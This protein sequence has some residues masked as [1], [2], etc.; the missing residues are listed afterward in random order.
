MRRFALIT[1]IAALLGGCTADTTTEGVDGLPQGLTVLNAE[2]GS[3]SMAY[4]SADVVIYM[5]SLRGRPTAEPYQN[6]PESPDF[7]VDARFTDDQ[8][9]VFYSQ[10]GGDG[11]VDAAWPEALERQIY[12]QPEADSNEILFRIAEDSA[13]T[14]YADIEEQLGPD[15]AAQLA[16]EI[17]ALHEFAVHAVEVYEDTFDT[18]NEI[19]ADEGMPQVELA[20]PEA[21]VAYGSSDG[22]PDDSPWRARSGRYYIAIHDKSIYEF[23]RHSSTSLRR[24]INGSW[25]HVHNACNHGSCGTQISQKCNYKSWSQSSNHIPSW[26]LRTCTTGYNAWSDSGG[27]NCHDDTR[28]QTSQ[29]IRGGSAWG[30]GSSRWCN[31]RDD[32]TDI[33]VNIWGFELDQSGSPSCSSSCRRGHGFCP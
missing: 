33:S 22:G 4:R 23:G 31:G 8:G 28:R 25:S 24:M 13:A 15:L 27:H 20:G 9:Y 2:V 17:R 32:D 7:E 10:Q 16:P 1:T 30:N 12:D 19:R 6:D 29:F 5:E 3:L 11:W 26:T 14:M 18:F 21:D